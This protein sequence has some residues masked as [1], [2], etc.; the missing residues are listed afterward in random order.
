MTKLTLREKILADVDDEH[1]NLVKKIQ[2]KYKLSWK[3]ARDYTN[4]SSRVL[5][6]GFPE[7]WL[8]R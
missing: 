7:E 1:F 5:M 4:W 3:R 8:K 6:L 2:K